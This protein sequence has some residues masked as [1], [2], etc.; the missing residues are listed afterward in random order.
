MRRALARTTLT[1]GSCVTAAHAGD[2][3][4]M[5]GALGMTIGGWIWMAVWVV[6]LIVMV[7]LL[8]APGNRRE[9]DDDPIEILRARFARGEMSE[10]EFRHARDILA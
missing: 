4:M 10:E 8:V 2:G 6:A 3:T 9:K 5:S 7:W 1:L